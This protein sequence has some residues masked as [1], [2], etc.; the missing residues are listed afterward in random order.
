MECRYTRILY[1]VYT[2]TYI[3]FLFFF[4]SSFHFAL[5]YSCAEHKFLFMGMKNGY[6]L[7]LGCSTPE[8]KQEPKSGGKGENTLF[9]VPNRR[10]LK[11]YYVAYGSNAVLLNRFYFSFDFILPFFQLYVIGICISD[12]LCCFVGVISQSFS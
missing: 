9:G 2:R 6:S 7:I 1:N 8:G 3:G 4:F 11:I 12:T 10:F 5:L